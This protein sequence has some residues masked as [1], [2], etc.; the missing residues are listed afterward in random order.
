MYPIASRDL[1]NLSGDIAF[2]NLPQNFTHLQVRVFVRSSYTSN[3]AAYS[4]L[5]FNG[6]PTA[7][8]YPN[9]ILVADGGSI[10][11]SSALSNNQLTPDAYAAPSAASTSN[12]FASLIWDI[13]DYTNT[14]KYKTVKVMAGF[15]ASGSGRVSLG[16]GFW[17]NTGAINQI[18]VTTVNNFVAGSR[19]DI[20]GI[21][22]SNATGA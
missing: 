5:Y 11:S 3:P 6:L 9:H 20:Y 18:N 15:D 4:G 10:S 17:T 12:V 7:N 8:N 2:T 13:F 19:I 16:S 14:N 22:T 21:S 1:S